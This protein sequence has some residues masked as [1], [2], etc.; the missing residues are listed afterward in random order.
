LR[1]PSRIRAE[2][3]AALTRIY[4]KGAGWTLEPSFDA[5]RFDFIANNKAIRFFLICID[6]KLLAAG[7]TSHLV[8]RM[9][10]NSSHL[11]GR[12]R[13]PSVFITNIDLTDTVRTFISKQGLILFHYKELG[14]IRDLANINVHQIET[15]DPR[16]LQVLVN[17][18]KTANQIIDHLVDK[19]NWA[20][21]IS[22][23]TMAART[24]GSESHA[25]VRL[26]QIK[27]MASERG[28]Y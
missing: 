25:G 12:Y 21:A 27:K 13:L 28:R 10:S 23:A 20:A 3:I 26:L 8:T 1:W 2:K 19:E 18:S 9:E 4:L 7:P 6:D 15:I 22:V 17:Y 16:Q 11:R 14:L 5:T 24:K